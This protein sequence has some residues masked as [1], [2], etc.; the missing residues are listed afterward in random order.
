MY[1]IDSFYTR[2]K[3]I[4]LVG[5]VGLNKEENEIKKGNDMGEFN[6]PLNEGDKL[7]VKARDLITKFENE[8]EPLE[9]WNGITE[10]SK[11][12]FVG[13]SKTGKTTFAENF[14]ISLAVGRPSFYGKE[15]KGGVKKILFIN[16]EE[17]PRM[18]SLR[19]KKQISRLN[20]QEMMLF[21]ENY[22]TPKLEFI[23][24]VN[25]DQDWE[26]LRD[27][28]EQSGADVIFI[29]SLTHLFQGQIESSQ[30]SSKFSKK[31]REFVT[32]SGKTIVLIHHTTKGND[33]PVEQDN[34]AGSRIILQEFEY[35]LA[36]ANIPNGQGKYSSMLFN[37]YVEVD[38]SIATVYEIDKDR[39]VSN[40]D[41]VKKLA[42][43]E[44]KVKIDYR[45]DST[46]QDLIYEYIQSQIS[47][48]SMTIK[49]VHL[50]KKFVENDTKI[51][52]RDTL[53]K[54]LDKLKLEGKI[55]SY[56][57]GEYTIKMKK[58]DEKGIEDNLQSD[59]L[60]N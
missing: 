16:L 9:I 41:E 4:R 12:L 26:K 36:F 57:R 55:D 19:L 58:G 2:R 30:D 42:L 22:L 51:M 39:W 3:L 7:V 54:S 31:F 33:K 49:S 37:K 6:N 38:S 28:I 15:I 10:G 14:A 35:A 32:S 20:H 46:N 45:R 40:L 5:L 8:P 59:K 11:G 1:K 25:S 52:S 47:Q 53:F 29:D 43:Y 34:I 60:Q 44:G 17:S 24:F 48:G 13:V 23:E 18:R 50:V 27:C 56:K 21:D